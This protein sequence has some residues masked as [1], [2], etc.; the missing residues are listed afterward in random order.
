MAYTL[1]KLGG[2]EH[3]LGDLR[4]R[5]WEM[6][7]TSYTTDGESITPTELGLSGIYAILVQSSE[8]GYMFAWDR[9]NEKLIVLT[10]AATQAGSTTD[11]GTCIVLAIGY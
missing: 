6:D 2:E 7:I 3:I 8:N 10:A 9:T 4:A 5:I 11:V 1:T